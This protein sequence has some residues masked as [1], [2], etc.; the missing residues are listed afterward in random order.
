M[1]KNENQ[2]KHPQKSNEYYT[3]CLAYIYWILRLLLLSVN[4]AMVVVR[5][6]FFCSRFLLIFVHL[7]SKS[8]LNLHAWNKLQISLFHVPLIFVFFC[9]LISLFTYIG[10][11]KKKWISEYTWSPRNKPHWR[12]SQRSLDRQ[13]FLFIGWDSFAI[14]EISGT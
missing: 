5:H 12:V 8:K 9:W 6:S 13:I 3:T 1:E 2:Q 11:F 14:L 7:T 10:T 4:N